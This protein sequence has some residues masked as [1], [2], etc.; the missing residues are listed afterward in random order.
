MEA[1]DSLHH[2]DHLEDSIGLYQ[3]DLILKKEASATFI[4]YSK[5]MQQLLHQKSRSK[6]LKEGDANTGY[7]HR[8]IARKRHAET[9]TSNVVYGVQ[10]EHV[11]EVKS[12]IYNHFSKLFP[13]SESVSVNMEDFEFMR[14][15]QEDNLMLTTT[16]SESEIIDAVWDCG[17]QKSPGPDGVNFQFIR[18]FWE[19]LKDDFTKFVTEFHSNGLLSKGCNSSFVALIPKRMCPQQIGDYRP[20]SLICCMYKVFSKILAN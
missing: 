14:I 20:I 12:S 18:K 2:Y 9:I 5:M 15:S 13:V 6:W 17:T 7:F 1:S 3:D 8:C 16:F 11:S 4:R 19:T 10:K